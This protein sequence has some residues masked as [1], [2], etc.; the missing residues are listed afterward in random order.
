LGDRKQK[1]VHEGFSSG[2]EEVDGGVP[3]WSVLDPLLFLLFINDITSELA[4]N[5]KLFALRSVDKI[6]EASI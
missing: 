1:V 6:S 2:W 4:C 5:I 3:Q